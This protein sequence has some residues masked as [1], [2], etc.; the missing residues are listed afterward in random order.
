[1]RTEK[2]ERLISLGKYFLRQ[3]QKA[4]EVLKVVALFVYAWNR[5]QTFKRAFSEIPA[6]VCGFVRDFVDD[7]V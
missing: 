1:M 6:H 5:R 7:L 2:E 4:V 3:N